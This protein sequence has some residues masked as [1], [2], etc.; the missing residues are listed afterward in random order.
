[1]RIKVRR[2][3]G[4]HTEVEHLPNLCEHLGSFF[5]VKQ[6]N[7]IVNEGVGKYSHMERIE[8]FSKNEN[9]QFSSDRIPKTTK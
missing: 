1:M 6:T 9:I 4:F 5:A 7:E 2:N 3:W 8:Y